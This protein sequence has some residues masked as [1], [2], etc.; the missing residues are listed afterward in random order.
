MPRRRPRVVAIGDAIVD[1]VT[2]P[3]APISSGDAQLRVRGLA[4]LPGGNATNFILQ[5]AALGDRAVFRGC[6]GDDPFAA[7]LRRAYRAHGVEARLRTDPRAATG[8]TVALTRSDGSRALITAPGA[9]ASLRERDVADSLLERADHIHRAGFW[10][11]AGLIAG[12]TQR[13]LA[14]AKRMGISTSMDIA[15]DPEAWLR[16]RVTAVRACLPHVDTFFGNEAEVCAVAGMREPTKAAGELCRRGVEAVVIHRG[17]KGARYVAGSIIE[18][19]EA[20]R[21]PTDNPTGCGDVFN[22]GFVHSKLVGRDIR[23][24]L[25]FANASA[26]LH[27]R[28]RLRPYPTAAQVRGFL[29]GVAS[30]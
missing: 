9:N 23:D 13:I 11:T 19:A 2:P 20:Y 24:S 4:V 16:A 26:A 30:R 5:I 6:V 18:E 7:V 3:L 27:L 15:T 8:A 28:D 21:V 12:P 17:A 29:R 14:R 25:R 10:W 22:A 1:I